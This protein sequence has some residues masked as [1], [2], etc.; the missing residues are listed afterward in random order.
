MIWD[1]RFGA[2]ILSCCAWG[3]AFWNGHRLNA[4]EMQRHIY[5]GTP[6]PWEQAA[7]GF[8]VGGFLGGL[9]GLAALATVAF[10]VGGPSIASE[11]HDMLTAVE[12]I[13]KNE[14]EI[15]EL[16]AGQLSFVSSNE[17]KEDG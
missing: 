1:Y 10:L 13:Q 12:Q 11:A 16:K 3:P 6:S 14:K 15:A 2:L 5:S 7:E 9:F 8:L 17:T 4:L